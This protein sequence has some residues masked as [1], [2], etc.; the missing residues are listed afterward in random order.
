[1]TLRLLA[2]TLPTLHPS[3]PE[4]QVQ[5]LFLA[6]P[7]HSVSLPSFHLTSQPFNVTHL[8]PSL[9]V[10][11]DANYRACG[12]SYCIAATQQCVSGIPARRS[13]TSATLSGSLVSGDALC[14]T[15]LTA[16]YLADYASLS[17]GSPV[18]W[19]CVDPASNLESCGGCLYPVGGLG[20][21]AQG[22]DC[23]A[24]EGVNG[25]S[26]SLVSGQTMM[27]LY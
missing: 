13:L 2:H 20:Q 14:P 11:C 26:V 22:R 8:I 16:C 7:V 21:A 23:T 19:E 3:A 24:I 15:G 10:A 1:M 25:V 18:S 9:H 6:Q 12:S 17:K 4:L 5:A 27:T